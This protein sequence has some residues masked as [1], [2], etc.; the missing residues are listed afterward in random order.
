DEREVLPASKLC[1]HLADGVRRVLPP[2]GG[3]LSAIAENWICQRFAASGQTEKRYKKNRRDQCKSMVV[4]PCLPTGSFDNT[5]RPSEVQRRR[6][7]ACDELLKCLQFLEH[8]FAF[9]LILRL[10]F[11]QI[12]IGFDDGFFVDGF[13]RQE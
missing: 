7:A 3:E 9:G 1:L 13:Q 2:A 5:T 4:H 12:A 8:A 10:L 11:E 6:I